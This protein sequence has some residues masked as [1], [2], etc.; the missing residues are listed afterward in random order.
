MFQGTR[1]SGAVEAVK[2]GDPF[3]S[4][5]VLKSIKQDGLLLQKQAS[6]LCDELKKAEKKHQRNR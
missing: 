1:S 5:V 2:S 4:A 3:S 6:I